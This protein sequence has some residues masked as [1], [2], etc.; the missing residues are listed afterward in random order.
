MIEVFKTNVTRKAVANR[1]IA[2]LALLFPGSRVNFDLEDC[3]KVLRVE[4]LDIC[5]EKT[6]ALLKG[7]GYDC[8]ELV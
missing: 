2:Q 3:D 1:L 8:L 4:G 6:I 7:E 5:C